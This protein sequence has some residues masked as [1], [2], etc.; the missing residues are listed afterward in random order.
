MSAVDISRKLFEP[1]KRYFGAVYQQGRVTLDSD[2]NEGAMLAA[3]ELRRLVAEAICGGG[4]P[5]V[6]FLVGEVSPAPVPGVEGGPGTFNFTI[7]AGSFYLGG[8]RYDWGEGETFLGQSDWLQIVLDGELP[9]PPSDAD[10]ANGPRHDLV[11]L[12]A[13]EECVT[14]TE[15][16]EILERA[17]GIDTTARRRRAR[18]VHVA[19]G[20]AADCAEALAAEL[21]Q[22]AGNRVFDPATGELVSPSRLTVAF[23]PAGV[24]D[25]PCKPAARAG[26]LGAD[27]QAFRVQVTAPGRFIWGANN[28]SPLYRVQAEPFEEPGGGT[29]P[30]RLRFLTLP[31]DQASFPLAGQAIELLRW[32]ALLPNHEKVAEPRGMLATI[33]SSFDPDD[34]SIVIATPVP[35]AWIDWFG[36]AGAGALSPRDPEEDRRYFY[37]RLWTGGSGEA[38]T[39]D[40]AFV[41]GTAQPLGGTGLTVAF[42]DNARAGDYWVIAAR[43]N[44]PDIVVPWALLEGAPLAGPRLFVAA[45]AVITWS[46]DANGAP[47]AHAHD[48]RHRFR[49]LC[50]IGGCCTIT[51]GDGEQSHGDLAS[52]QQAIDLL[53]ASGGEVCV[54]RGSYREHVVIDGRENVVIKG[55]GPDSRILGED[56]GTE[57]LVAIR[58]SRAI[59][60]EQ[61]GFDAPTVPAIRIDGD[62]QQPV[63]EVVLE[64]LT[65]GAR[66]GVAVIGT[67]LLDAVLR[68]CR[69]EV[70]A[71]AAGL[72]NDL[73]SGRQ[74]AVFLA[75]NDLLV[76]R[77]RIEVD[78][79]TQRLHQALGGVQIGGGSR[80][81]RLRDNLIRGGTGH[82]ITLGSVRFVRRGEDGPG[83]TL[84]NDL[85]NIAPVRA[86]TDGPFVFIGMA[87][88]VDQDGCISVDPEPPNPPGG[89]NQP[90]LVP[91]SDGALEDVAILD[92]RIEEMGS[93]G[94]S[95]ARFFD[96]SQRPDYISV[97]R[98]EIARNRIRRCVGLELPALAGDF[99]VHA[100]FGGVALA[101]CELLAVRDN[102]IADCGNRPGDPTCGI[103]VLLAETAIIE[104]NRVTENGIRSTDQAPALPGRRGGV[105]IGFAFPGSSP[106]TLPFFNRAGLRQNGVPALRLH[107]NVVVAPEGRAV[108]VIAVGPLSACDNQLTSRGGARLFRTAVGTVGAT[109]GFGLAAAANTPPAAVAGASGDPLLAFIDLLGG[110]VVAILDLGMSTELYLR[111]LGFA[112]LGIVDP[113]PADP[114]PFNDEDDNLFFGGEVLFD[115]NQVVL[116]S[117]DAD[118]R[119]AASAVL[120]VSTDDVAMT[121][122][123]CS[124]DLLLDFVLTNA[125]VL[126]FSVRVSDNRLKEPMDLGALRQAFLSAITFGLMNVT[127]ENQGTHCFYAVGPAVLSVLGPNRSLIDAFV[128]A[129]CASFRRQN[130]TANGGFVVG[131]TI[132]Q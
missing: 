23:D 18:R 126:G 57:P 54:L 49:P 94:I 116:D 68:G 39:P 62:Y 38:A 56:Q 95:V 86:T 109:P 37:L 101:H 127:A 25:D 79:A 100:A 53:P 108:E 117:L 66:D 3:E 50:E 47:T 60:L 110:A 59:R 97:E 51:V 19:T 7:A 26:Y 111:F 5:N 104:Q 15:D 16:S 12:E 72:A 107:D 27:N 75:G 58:R 88:V 90:P 131:R 6:G 70:A 89:P 30:R 106:F 128:P 14:A 76:E 20:T 129:R 34:A 84:A 73:Q 113:G 36:G 9:V 61:L 102:E 99:R 121:G 65:I 41:P 35:Q 92:N 28:A 130:D 64:T 31:R 32:G 118:V 40:R 52:I 125:L 4:S 115:A 46:L 43:P 114:T 69:I 71:L 93:S 82:G 105:V 21:A 44:T 22:I 74:P 77:C 24:A 119:V 33:E 124:C 29:T 120:L 2:Q 11:W 13:S 42:S 63:R 122:N 91:V 80:R 132:N 96:L 48:C 10:L 98:L 81:V 112:G 67:G 45:L 8:Q 83:G 1:A 55:C 87:V 78:P 17:V 85:V 123:Q 103:F